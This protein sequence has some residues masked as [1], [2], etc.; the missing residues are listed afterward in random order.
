[1]SDLYAE[2][3]HTFTDLLDEATAAG[4]PE[5]TAM[6]VATVGARWPAVGA[7]RAAQGLR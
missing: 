5:P 7:H 3:L 6:T 2:A 1:M 4:D